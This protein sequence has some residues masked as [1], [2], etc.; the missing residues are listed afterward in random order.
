MEENE[1]GS[2][3]KSQSGRNR[4]NVSPYIIQCLI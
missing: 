1:E 4:A 2:Q 3:V